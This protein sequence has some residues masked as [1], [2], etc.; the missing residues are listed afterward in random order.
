VRLW[1][2]Q[3]EIADAIGDVTLPRVTLVKP[4]RV[5]FSTLLTA[6]VGSFV[7][8]DPAPILCLLPTE[9]DCRGY[10]VDDIEPI[11]DASP[12]L[13]GLL[14]VDT[15]EGARNTLVHRRFRG[16]SLKVIAAKAPRNLRRHNVRVLL[17]DE[18]DAMEVTSEGSPIKLAEKRTMSFPDR[19]IVLGSTPLH[20]ETSHVLRA[21]ADSDQRVFELPC[22]ECGTFTE[23]LWSHIEWESA[24]PETAAFRCPHCEH[25]IPERHKAQMVTEGRWRP[26]RPEVKGHAGFRLNALVSLLVNASWAKLA[27]E[28]LSAKDDPDQLQTFVNTILAQGWRDAAEELDESE[29]QKRSEPWGLETIPE[30]VL[31]IT[32]G[33]DVQDD[34]LE[35]S[36]VGWSR[37]ECFVLG[38]VVIWGTPDDETTWLEL[39]ELLRT[40]W[41]HP[42]GGN[43]KVD[44]AMVD[45]GDGD[46]TEKVYSYCFA[47][48]GRRIFAC[49][50]A[51]GNR[52]FIQ[53]SK[54]KNGRLFIIGVDVIKTT[55]MNRLALKRSI[56]FSNS[57]Q[58]VYFEQLASERKVLRYVRGQPVKRFERKPGA[59]AETLDCLVYATAARQAVNVNLDHREGE[60]R[61]TM[62]PPAPSVIRSKWLEGG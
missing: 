23:I 43:L 30:W 57:L 21:Y 58:P 34:R 1:P 56:R 59:R 3:R 41:K 54:A 5:G 45:S 61:C 33:V 19:K 10:M 52:P 35:V 49:K 31:V 8:N 62:L 50:G 20:E 25:L 53:A 39:D 32:C 40:R 13:R 22:P 29:L 44:A 7:A 27:A 24:A 36:V 11:F 28:F 12:E 9:A 46:W 48:G 47:R 14:S 6:V 55:V 37:T 18:A 60:L 26:M 16:G 17:I 4:V 38:H 2:Y 15:A 51:A 42:H